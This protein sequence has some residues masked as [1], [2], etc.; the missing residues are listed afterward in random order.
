MKKERRIRPQ[1]NLIEF[2]GGVVAPKITSSDDMFFPLESGRITDN[3]F[4]IKDDDVNLFVY[5]DGE[6]TVCIDCGLKNTPALAKEL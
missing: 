4:A 6:N 3:V 2:W 1:F 5:T